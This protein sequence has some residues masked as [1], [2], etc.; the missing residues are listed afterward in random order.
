MGIDSLRLD[1]RVA[2]AVGVVGFGSLA[3]LTALF[4]VGQPFGTLNDIGNGTL[5]VLSGVLAATT[6][7]RRRG[8]AVETAAVASAVVGAAFAVAGSALVISGT[9]GFFLAGLVS[10]VGFALIGAWLVAVNWSAGSERWP[11]TLRALGVTAG[12][13]MLFG[14]VMV[15]GIAMQ[16]DDMASAPTWIWIGFV[17]WIGTFVLYPAWGLWAG[18][19]AVAG[20]RSSAVAEPASSG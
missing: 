8:S 13:T 4:A 10:S 12:V 19:L 6:L 20:A 2:V 17:G 1:G 3:S 15:P 16:L 7:S 9:T 5:G 18:R 11:R 14:V